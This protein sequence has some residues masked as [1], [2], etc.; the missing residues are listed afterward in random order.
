MKAE[1]LITILQSEV[2]RLRKLKGEDVAF[3][4][5]MAPG[6][7]NPSTQ[8]FTGTEQGADEFYSFLMNTIQK[9]R[10]AAEVRDPYIGVA[11][12]MGRR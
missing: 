7:E 8:L 2:S 1:A 10:K 4:F 9:A 11:G 5:V 12:G 3:F 6:S